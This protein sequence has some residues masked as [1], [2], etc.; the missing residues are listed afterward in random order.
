MK[1]NQIFKIVMKNHKI[2][3]KKQNKNIEYNLKLNINKRIM[4]DPGDK[5]LMKIKK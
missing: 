5:I 2:N 3:V 1:I 4:T